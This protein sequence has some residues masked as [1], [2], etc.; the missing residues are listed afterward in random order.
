[1]LKPFQSQGK[2]HSPMKCA[3][4][5]QRFIVLNINEIIFWHNVF[6]IAKHND[7]SKTALPFLPL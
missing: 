5:M 7:R 4:D 2:E 1:V 6:L 3:V